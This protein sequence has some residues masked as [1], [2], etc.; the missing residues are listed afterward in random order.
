MT[1]EEKAKALTNDLR[2]V[3]E[4]H[5]VE[6]PYFDSQ[7]GLH[8]LASL[9][10]LAGEM[11]FNAALVYPPETMKD[12]VAL[13]GKQVCRPMEECGETIK[14]MLTEGAGKVH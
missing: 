5:G 6:F 7:L 13:F 1:R 4:H 10:A 8:V 3:L 11:L 9:A 2:A 12:L 14:K